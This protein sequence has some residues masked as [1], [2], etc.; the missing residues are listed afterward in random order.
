MDLFLD[1]GAEGADFLRFFWIL[2][3]KND[4]IACFFWI[5]RPD[6]FGFVFLDF[7]AEGA[8]F[9]WIS[10]AAEGGRF[11]FGFRKTLKKTLTRSDIIR[12]I[13]LISIT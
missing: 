11:F 10:G 13:V 9:F 4:E 2:G 12:G 6:F 5:S 7:G 3:R 1:F 8:D